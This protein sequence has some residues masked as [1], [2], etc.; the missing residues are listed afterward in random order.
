MMSTKKGKIKINW[1]KPSYMP[2]AKG[3]P[4]QYGVAGAIIGISHNRLM[5]AGGANF[6]DFVPWMGG[7]K[8]YHDEV[9]LLKID[10]PRKES[11]CEATTKLPHKI[12]YSACV[13][14]NNRVFA[15]GGEDEQGPTNKTWSLEVE[16]NNLQCKTLT[17][18]PHPVSAG[19]A[20]VIE[21]TVY[22]AG[23]INS[24]DNTTNFICAE[25][26]QPSL[27]W[28]TLP[29]LP[30]AL[31]HAVVVA[32]N[33]GDEECIFVVGGRSKTGIVSS[34]YSLIWKYSPSKKIWIQA[35][36]L[37]EAKGL[38]MGL[39]AGTGVAV[40]NRYIVLL[41]GDRGIVFNQTERYLDTIAR[42]SDEEEKKRLTALKNQGQENHQGFLRDVI[43]F[44]TITGQ[45]QKAGRTNCETQVTTL[46]VASG[47][48]IYIPSGEIRPGIR[49]AMVSKGT[50][51]QL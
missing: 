43:V 27:R 25:L 1:L 37:T 39:S 31:S 50:F 36:E 2:P 6:E 42:T 22:L 19:G 41:G 3:K 10:Q 44:D 49:T 17:P 23:G 33:D 29:D 40:G 32:Q 13:S 8:Q 16:G 20:A 38:P 46:A 21:N 15:L 35:G 45:S 5:V 4:V 12:G 26:D 7:T 11:W 47:N 24:K 18:L 30:L 14:W 28:K 48:T 34:F 9:Y 51:R